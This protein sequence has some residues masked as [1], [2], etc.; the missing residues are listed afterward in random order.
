MNTPTSNNQLEKEETASIEPLEGQRGSRSEATTKKTE[1]VPNKVLD[2]KPAAS[3]RGLFLL[4]NG[5]QY[6]FGKSH[7]DDD[8]QRPKPAGNNRLGYERNEK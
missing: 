8:A 5:P 3:P 1:A 6:F 2:F 4:V 7:D